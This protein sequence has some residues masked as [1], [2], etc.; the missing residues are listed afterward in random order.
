M[1]KRVDY[2]R[3]YRTVVITGDE[4]SPLPETVIE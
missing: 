3:H 1:S 2:I 4:S